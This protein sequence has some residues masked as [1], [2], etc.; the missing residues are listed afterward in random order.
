M[1]LDALSGA[2]YNDAAKLISKPRV[3]TTS[4][5]ETSQATI[6][7][8][9]L[10]GT[11]KVAMNSR[12]SK[13]QNSGQNNGQNNGSAS[14]QQIK[15]AISKA[16]NKLKMHRT[17]CEFSYHEETK[18]V[19]I[20]VLDEDTKEVIREIPPEQT[21]EMVERMWELAGLLVDEKR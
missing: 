10:P 1:A 11:S 20:K 6:N 12:T 4:G 5:Q 13:E 3:E 9:E 7:I 14:D 17:R 19:S 21:L 18:R 15:D 2:I 16:N 8:T